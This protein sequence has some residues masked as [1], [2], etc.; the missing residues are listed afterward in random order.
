MEI[1]NRN[2]RDQ[3]RWRLAAMVLVVLACNA[4]ILWASDTALASFGSGG[5]KAGRASLERDI[6][7]M[8]AQIQGARNDRD[9]VRLKREEWR[10]KVDK[11][12]KERTRWMK[13][14]EKMEREY[15][16]LSAQ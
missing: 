12:S 6:I 14:K 3:A 9:E 10:K 1:L 15:M 16:Q 7:D 5:K 2:I 4:V 11:L 8:R 13:D